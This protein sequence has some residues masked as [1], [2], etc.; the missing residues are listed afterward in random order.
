VFLRWS[1]SRTLRLAESLASLQGRNTDA[2]D[3]ERMLRIAPYAE[4]EAIQSISV[5]QE[6]PYDWRANTSL[7]RMRPVSCIA[8][9]R[10]RIEPIV[11]A[12]PVKPLKKNA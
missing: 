3:L 5:D 9:K 6:H 7:Q 8:A 4:F 12:S 1:L 2:L 11:I 10:V